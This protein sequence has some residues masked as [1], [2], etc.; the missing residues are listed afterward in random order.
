M[1]SLNLAVLILK[2]LLHLLPSRTIKYL[3]NNICLPA[4]LLTFNTPLPNG[5]LS[6]A[7]QTRD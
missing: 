2:N 7:T 3:P 5:H 1:N 6:L 4:V